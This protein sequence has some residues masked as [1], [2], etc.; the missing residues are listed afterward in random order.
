MARSCRVGMLKGRSLPFFL[1]I[2]IRR[3]GLGLYPCRLRLSA[4]WSFCRLVRHRTLSTPGVLAPRLVVT[5]HTARSL[6]ARECV[7]SHCRAR[8]LRQLPSL[9]ALAIR[10][11]SRRTCCRRVFHG[12]CLQSLGWVKDASAP[13]GAV[14]C[15]SFLAL[16]LLILL[17]GET[18]PT[19]AYPAHY[20]PALAFSVLS[21]LRLLTRLAVRS[22]QCEAGRASSFSMFRNDL[23][24]VL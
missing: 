13:G 17:P 8:A 19:W 3:R 1:R 4:A 15:F 20:A 21:M 14:I 2:Y 18:R 5:R 7:S 23:Y 11:C 9:T 22:A 16:V 6:A 12:I 10:I 24:W